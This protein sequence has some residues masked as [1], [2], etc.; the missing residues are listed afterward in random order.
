MCVALD[1]RYA[2]LCLATEAHRNAFEGQLN[3][4]GIDV[5]AV[6]AEGRLICLDAVATLARVTVDG[7]LDVERFAAVVGA[8]VDR[9]AT[10]FQRV[11]V[12]GELVALMYESGNIAGALALEELWA[13]FIESRPVFL[14]CAYP[15]RAFASQESWDSFL[16]VC[17]THCRVM[18]RDS[19][20]ARNF[21]VNR[22][23]E[24]DNDVRTISSGS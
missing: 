14:H 13:S 24:A 4:R 6:R 17:Q 12:F 20:L 8:T 10:A 22:R 1:Q 2:V 21:R 11:W 19:R 23:D 5:A 16:Q 7:K 15:T 9:L 18:H 3:A